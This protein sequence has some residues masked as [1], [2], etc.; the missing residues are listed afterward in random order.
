MSQAVLFALVTSGALIAGAF[1]GMRWMPEKRLLAA[2]LAFAAGAL[3]AALAFELFEESFAKG[4]HVLSSVGF[5]GGAGTF[6]VI[7]VLLERRRKVAGG[8]G[9]GVALLAG[10]V[11]DGIPENVALG[12]TLAA[13]AGSLA[14]LAAIVVSNFP[15]ALVGARAM[16]DNGRSAR[17]ALG[18]WCFAA[19]VLAIAVIA[20][21]SLLQ[22]LED[23]ALSVI[24]AFAG[25]AV[26]ASVANTLFP[27][28]YQDGG[29]WVTLTTVAGFLVAFT[30]GAIG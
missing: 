28:A 2:L 21:S 7:D 8:S 30:L 27:K 15:E 16:C 23:G 12:T 11:L 25:G 19:V 10:V 6:I 1:T 22:N 18:T 24:L 20:G 9:V 3:T 26:L 13:G 17:F 5:A 4:G 14:L 29:P